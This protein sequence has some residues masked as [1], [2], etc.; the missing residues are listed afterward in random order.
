MALMN[1]SIWGVVLRP[2]D[3]NG[4]ALLLGG[5]Q[6]ARLAPVVVSGSQEKVRAGD[7]VNDL[8][9]RAGLPDG[10][11]ELTLVDAIGHYVGDV[12]RRLLYLLGGRFRAIRRWQRRADRPISELAPLV[13]RTAGGLDL[14]TVPSASTF[15]CSGRYG[16]SPEH[17]IDG[18]GH[19]G[20]DDDLGPTLNLDQDVEGRGGAT[21]EHC[22]L[23]PAPS[24]LYVSQCH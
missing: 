2:Q 10:L 19:V 23:R 5:L 17:P 11:L 21:L 14:T 18:I 15:R 22:L 6:G 13:C 7:V 3:V 12:N 16:V 4:L 9:G 20:M 8:N 24:C 1:C